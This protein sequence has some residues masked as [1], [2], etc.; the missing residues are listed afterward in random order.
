VFELM[1][2]ISK[3]D[4][5]AKCPKCD[6]KDEK[7]VSVFAS[8]AEGTLKVPEKDALREGYFFLEVQDDSRREM[9]DLR[10]NGASMV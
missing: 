2:P 1:R 10:R 8:A 7:L 4:E 9:R 6:S 5:P 3:A